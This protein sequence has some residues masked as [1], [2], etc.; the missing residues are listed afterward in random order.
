MIVSVYSFLGNSALTGP[1]VYINIYTEEFGISQAQA[2]GLI[3]YPNLAFGFGISYLNE[4]VN[5]RSTLIISRVAYPCAFISENWE[6][7]SFTDVYVHGIYNTS[8][9]FG[10]D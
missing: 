3:S 7:A 1:S 5:M 8:Q 9:P 10:A 4:C 6:K 2:S